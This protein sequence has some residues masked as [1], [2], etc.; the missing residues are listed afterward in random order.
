MNHQQMWDMYSRTVNTDSGYSAWSF[1]AD[2]DTLAQLVLNG[3]KTGTS[4]LY[5][6][7]ERGEK[8]PV[9][10]EYSVVLDSREEAVCIIRTTKVYRVPFCDVGKKHA[11][12]EGEGDRSLSYW[13]KVHEQFFTEELKEIGLPFDPRMIVV[14]EEFEKVF[15]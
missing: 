8:M 9:S 1:G 13:R 4:S 11:F 14:C 7:Y 3:T 12:L 2:P 10:G 6:W 5:L 15:P